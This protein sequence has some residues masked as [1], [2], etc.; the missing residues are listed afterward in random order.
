MGTIL[1][2]MFRKIKRCFYNMMHPSIG[3]VWMLHRVTNNHSDYELQRTYE[4]TPARLEDL[5]VEY[6]KKGY[7]FVSIADVRSIV[8]GN[9]KIKGKFVSVTLDDG[10]RD[11]YEVAYPIFKQYDIPFCIYL[12]QNEVS[13]D[14]IGNYPML[15]VEQILELDK[16]DLC[17]LGSHTYSHPFLASM[18]RA[19]QYDEIAKCNKWIE[20]LVGH[21]V[22]DFSYPHGSFNHDTVS[23]LRE[24]GINQCPMAWG[25]KLRKGKCDEFFI[26]RCIV[27][28]TNIE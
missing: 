2:K 14:V 4:I 24:I 9:K 5:I 6:K 21:K 19:D 25:G 11:N 17:T 26:P 3:E 7:S 8:S 13:G 20:K 28:E 27:T 16:D 22:V 23:I 10:Y 15:T 12:L 18:K 1:R